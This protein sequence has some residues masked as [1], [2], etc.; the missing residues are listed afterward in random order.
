[1]SVLNQ[2]INATQLSQDVELATVIGQLNQSPDKLQQFLQDQQNSIFQDVVRQ[3]GSTFDKVYGD[4]QRASNSQKAVIM[5][6]KRNTELAN[7]QQQ[8]YENQEKSA[9]IITEDKNLAER[10]YEMNQWSV[11]NKND[12]LFVFSSLF[13]LL[14][15]LIILTYLWRKTIISSQYYGTLSGF[16]ILIFILIVIYRANFTNIWRNNRYWN[17]RNFDGKYGKIPTPQCEDV[18]KAG[19]DA[20]NLASQLGD[21]FKQGMEDL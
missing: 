1:M 7:I 14:S 11:S 3:K 6:D 16:F 15:S 8:I 2:I 21:K 5:L 9:V 4:L 13:I 19:T 12:T 20:A 17:R 18:A 10:K